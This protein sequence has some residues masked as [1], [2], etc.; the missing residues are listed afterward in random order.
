MYCDLHQ[1]F[2]HLC[3][4]IQLRSGEYNVCKSLR[5]FW[6]NKFWE[7][8]LYLLCCT[9]EATEHLFRRK[10][11]CAK[12]S[13]SSDDKSSRLAILTHAQRHRRQ[14]NRLVSKKM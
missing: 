7:S 6:Y 9:P 2:G 11:I 8:I 14:V 1:A 4:K 12:Y 13:V 5:R 10:V 3:N